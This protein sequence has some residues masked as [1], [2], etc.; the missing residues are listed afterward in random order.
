MAQDPVCGMEVDEKKA[1]A[2]FRRHDLR[3]LVR[4]GIGA[5]FPAVDF[6]DVSVAHPGPGNERR[7]G[8]Q[9]G[10]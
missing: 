10:R 5:D 8:R 9:L 1:P 7:D 2:K 4:G 3:W 6:G